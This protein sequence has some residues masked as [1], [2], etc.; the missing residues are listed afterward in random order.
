M[1][2]VKARIAATGLCQFKDEIIDPDLFFFFLFSHPH[3][4]RLD[5]QILDIKDINKYRYKSEQ[6]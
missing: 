1:T 3:R 6:S 2:L 5:R 4:C